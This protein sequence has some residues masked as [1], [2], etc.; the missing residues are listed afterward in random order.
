VDIRDDNQQGGCD[1]YSGGLLRKQDN[2]GMGLKADILNGHMGCC[3]K[4]TRRYSH[5]LPVEAKL[6]QKSQLSAYG[7]SQNLPL[8]QKR[9][10]TLTTH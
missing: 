6:C 4:K 10:Q 3:R 8:K 1:I 9:E 5:S 7:F 2:T